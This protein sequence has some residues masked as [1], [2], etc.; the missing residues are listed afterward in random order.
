MWRHLA[1]IIPASPGFKNTTVMPR[2]H[3][4]LGPRG[5]SGEF[6]SAAGR[7]TSSWRVRHNGVVSFNVSLPVGVQAATLIVPKPLSLYVSNGKPGENTSTSRT[8]VKERGRIVW[9]GEKLVGNH[10]GLRSAVDGS[11][12]VAFAVSNGLYIFES[13]PTTYS[14]NV[15]A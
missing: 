12:G 9:D 1:G 14:N 8:V 10:H 15:G 5:V 4:T 3:A 6:I 7:I 13:E 2:I 11:E